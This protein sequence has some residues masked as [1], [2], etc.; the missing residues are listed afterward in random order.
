MMLE[1]ESLVKPP[2]EKPGIGVWRFMID[3]KFQGRGIGRAALLL[4]ID[5][6][7]AKASLTRWNCRMCRARV[8]LS[9]FTVASVLSRLAGW[10]TAKLFLRSRWCSKWTRLG[11]GY[12][13]TQIK[14][15]ESIPNAPGFR[16]DAFA[17]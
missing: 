12:V 5:M 4:V 1:D 17:Y 2:S 9:L 11:A 10:T 8:A 15:C 13:P 6:H 3:E 16:S 14:Y 7:E